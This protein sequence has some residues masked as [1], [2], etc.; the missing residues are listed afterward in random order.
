MVMPIAV[1]VVSTATIMT[2]C[3]DISRGRDQNTQT[4]SSDEVVTGE[5]GVS[6]RARSASERADQED[7]R[8]HRINVRCHAY[9]SG[10]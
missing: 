6:I 10:R 9:L 5:G 1:A 8:C 4:M 3:A 2:T 7:Y